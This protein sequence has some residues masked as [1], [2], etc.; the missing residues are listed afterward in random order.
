MRRVC[1]LGL[2]ILGEGEDRWTA[3]QSGGAWGSLG[4]LQQPDLPLH[5]RN[6]GEEDSEED[7]ARGDMAGSSLNCRVLGKCAPHTSAPRLCSCSHNCPP[8]HPP[9]A[10][11]S[12]SHP[13]KLC[14][15]Q[16]HPPRFVF[17]HILVPAELCSLSTLH[18]QGAEPHINLAPPSLLTPY[19]PPGTEPSP[20]PKRGCSP[21][22][23]LQSYALTHSGAPL[24]TQW[25]SNHRGSGQRGRLPV[26]RVRLARGPG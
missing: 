4:M 24:P 17:L 7:K 23:I 5:P 16:Q 6:V 11:L 20:N 8:R 1:H 15:H 9:R 10:V 3:G 14:A 2:G 13:L 21:L 26:P 12:S 19:L 25:D 22:S 18:L